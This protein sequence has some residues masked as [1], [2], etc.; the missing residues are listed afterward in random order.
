MLVS[1]P[2]AQ[3]LSGPRIPAASDGYGHVVALGSGTGGSGLDDHVGDVQR[4]LLELVS[5]S[6]KR[7]RDHLPEQPEEGLELDRRRPE[8][9]RPLDAEKRMRIQDPVELGGMHRGG[10]VPRSLSRRIFC[11]DMQAIR[12]LA[13]VA[14][15]ASAA[16]GLAGCNE[17]SS[18]SRAT[19]SPREET[20]AGLRER[21]F[22]IE[23]LAA[24]EA[25]PTSR[26]H[27][28]SPDF[29]P[30]L[31]DGPVYPVGFSKRGV[32]RFLYPPPK[33]SVFAGS[34][35]GGQKVLWVSDPKYAG[36]ILIGGR[37]VDGP[38]R[39]QFG[40]GSAR[41]LR[42]LAFG[43]QSAENWTGGW[44]NFPSY[45]PSGARLLRVPGRRR[46][47]QRRHLLPSRRLGLVSDGRQS[48]TNAIV[49]RQTLRESLVIRYSVT[50]F[51]GRKAPVQ[52]WWKP[53]N[54]VRQ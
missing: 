9:G 53:S 7:R 1:S 8:L 24:G 43:G 33:N 19:T 49:I 4:D 22:H 21:P 47:L 46:R 31:G 25:C 48:M 10:T 16:V 39:L 41:L 44:R 2:G 37:Q 54:S 42:E 36:P 38:N 32:L 15:L 51:P 18:A 13:G 27:A 5:V 35:W 50:R 17:G 12:L 26:L 29:G 40:Q 20:V 52:Q 28:I 14:A 23:S 6:H 11:V 3:N 45:T 34:V 30:G